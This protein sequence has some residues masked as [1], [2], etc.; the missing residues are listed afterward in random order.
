[1]TTPSSWKP[2]TDFTE[3]EAKTFIGKHALV[4]ITHRS[5]EDKVVSLEQFHGTIVRL[6]PREG[7][8][9][10]LNNS[11]EE[12]IIPPDISRLEMARPGHYTLKKTGEV[13]IDP[14][15]TVMWT[16]YP[17]GYKG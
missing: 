6:S 1:M 11:N 14:D 13:V 17:K 9:I 15:Y 16:Q 8:V 10:K 2:K 5:L 4:G 7:L 3:E 12:R